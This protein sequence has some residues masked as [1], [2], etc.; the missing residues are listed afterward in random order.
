MIWFFTE[1]LGFLLVIITMYLPGVIAGIISILVWLRYI[2]KIAVKYNSI[3]KAVIT[4]F[5]F[6][7]SIILLVIL[8]SIIVQPLFFLL[9]QY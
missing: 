9:P 6:L 3:I 2:K 8:F 7:I 1:D 5:Y 4:V